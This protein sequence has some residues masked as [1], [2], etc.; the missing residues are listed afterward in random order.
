MR[1]TTFL[2]TELLLPFSLFAHFSGKSLP[3]PESVGL[4]IHGNSFFSFSK[5]LEAMRKNAHDIMDHDYQYISGRHGHEYYYQ[6]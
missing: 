4:L 1:I 3:L 6:R 5:D 2:F